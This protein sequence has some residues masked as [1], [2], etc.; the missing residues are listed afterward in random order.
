MKK[1]ILTIL[2]CLI[3]IPLCAGTITIGKK[4]AVAGGGPYTVAYRSTSESATPATSIDKPSSC[5]DTDLMLLTCISDTDEV[6]TWPDGWT[7][8]A[9]IASASS[10]LE[11][12]YKV[13]SSEGASYQVTSATT[14]DICS[15]SCFTKSGGT[16]QIKDFS[17]TAALNNVAITSDAVTA[18]SGDSILYIGWGCDGAYLNRTDGEYPPA[19]MTK[20]MDL[21]DG[22]VPAGRGTEAWY[23]D[24]ASAGDLTKTFTTENLEDKSTIAVVINAE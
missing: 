10:R 3:A 4:K 5:A 22:G 1:I 23:Q 7:E 12:A 9:T 14:D 18:P 19:G 2:L 15:I 16:W 13:A 6:Q 17:S 20:V 24:I 21:I 11:M 8:I